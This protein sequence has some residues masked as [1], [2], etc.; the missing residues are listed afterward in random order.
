MDWQDQLIAIY[1]YLCKQY[2]AD[3]W[4]CVQRFS[5]HVE[6]QLTDE[7]VITLYWFG[8]LDGH[9]TIK[10]I[11]TYADRHLRDWFP[12]LPSYPAY[13][14]RLNRLA[15]LF[16]PLLERI[17]S[18][19]PPTDGKLLVDS[20]PVALAR[21]GHRFKACVAANIADHGYCATKKLYFYGVRVH[22]IGRKQAGTLPTPEYIGLL[23]A[24]VPDG[25]VFDQIRPVL[26]QEEVFGDKA[27]QRPDAADVE[28]SQQL[29]VRTP[30]KKKKGQR[31][32]DA[33]EQ[34]LSTAVSQ[35]RQ[36]IETL[37][38]WIEKKTGI[39]VASN[40][41]SYQGLLVHVFGR[42]AAALF[43]WNQ[44]RKCP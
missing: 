12:A 11:H 37:F 44:L 9:R 1:L 28:Q 31:Y 25:K 6:L 19:V 35:V 41:R 18:Q 27:Y 23:P 14:M 42:L 36:P 10:Q 7:E 4:A 39:E 32:L 16:A 26:K 15:D 8:L 3:L 38:A 17:Q 34:W 33:D 40:V 2:K 5:P 22:V 24:S 13:V 20:F 30:V 21:Q 43:F 29:T